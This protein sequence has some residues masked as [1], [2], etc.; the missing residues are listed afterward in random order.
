MSTATVNPNTC[1]TC[2]TTAPLHTMLMNDQGALTCA[3]CLA[4]SEAQVGLRKRTKNMML[5]P[6]MAS[7]LAYF[8]FVVPFLNIFLPGVLAAL[9]ILS[10]V[11]GIKL[12][13]EL[14]RRRDDHGVSEGLRTGL[15]VMSILT[16]IFAS[17]PLLMQVFAWIGLA[18]GLSHPRSPTW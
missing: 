4:R 3:S 14:G 2:G 9:A 11:T 16:I 18:T 17:I 5:A 10:A 15:L 8:S 12:H 13:G 7:V 1:T 6:A